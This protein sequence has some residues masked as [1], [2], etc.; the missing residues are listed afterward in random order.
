[1]IQDLNGNHV[2]QKCLNH[3]SS[4][5]C[6]F[7]FDAVAMNCV[8]VGTHRHG[9][10]VIQRCIDHASGD[11]KGQLIA[12]ITNCSFPLVQDPFGNYV[13]QYICKEA[14]HDLNNLLMSHS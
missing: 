7:I 3:L 4:D 12:A 13:L 5:D 8:V 11:Q 14:R 6:Q 2:V 10:C 9:C 1:M